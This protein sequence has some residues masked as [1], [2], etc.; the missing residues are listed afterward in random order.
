V[1]RG[2]D[3]PPGRRLHCRAEFDRV[4]R[5]GQR[6]DGPLFSVLGGSGPSRLGIAAGR[7]VG[8]SVQRNRAKRL[9]RD[10]FRRLEGSLPCLDLVILVKRPLVLAAQSEVDHEFVR[11]LHSLHQRLARRG[12]PTAPVRH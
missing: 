4:F 7:A 3:F 2:Q 5:Q 11:R 8:G 9:L 10:A 12:G 1:N 6:V